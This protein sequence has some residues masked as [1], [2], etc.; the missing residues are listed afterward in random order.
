MYWDEYKRAVLLVLT[1]H[2]A[3]REYDLREVF[4]TTMATL[5][6]PRASNRPLSVS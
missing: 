2:N 3:K 4:Q 6:L 5:G 1:K